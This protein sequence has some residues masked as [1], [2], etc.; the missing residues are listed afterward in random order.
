MQHQGALVEAWHGQVFDDALGLDVAEGA[1]LAADVAAH[2]AVGPQDDDVGADAHALQLLDRVLG[3]L[4]LVLVGAGDVGHQ[5]HVDVAAVLVALLDAHLADGL[6]ERLALDVAGGAADLGDDHVGLGGGGQVVDVALDLV[7]DV[8]DDLDGLAQIRALAL[9][10]QDVPVDLAGGQVGVLV[11]VLVDEALIVAQVQ[12]GLGAVVGDEHLAVLQG[13]HGAGVHVDI[14]V[15]LLAGYLE[16][17]AFE[18]PPQAGRG[19]PLAQARDHAAGHK[20]V[21]RRHSFL[22]LP[23]WSVGAVTEHTE[24]AR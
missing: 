12:V 8:G 1:D 7:G 13:A 23:L 14:G 18:Q 21:F 5:H 17:A 24:G 15:Q 9:L 4:G 20:D 2:A 3:G 11:Q 10:V 16:A 6:Q 19:D 22:H